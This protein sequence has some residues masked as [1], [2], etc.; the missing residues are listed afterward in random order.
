MGGRVTYH[1]SRISFSVI[2]C[3]DAFGCICTN[4]LEH[5]IRDTKCFYFFAAGGGGFCL[6]AGGGAAAACLAGGFCMPNAA[7]VPG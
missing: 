3:G 5:E 2:I 4:H 1:V 7:L 6:L